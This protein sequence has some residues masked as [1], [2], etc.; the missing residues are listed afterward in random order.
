M[1]PQ[2]RK[3]E[4]NML[5]FRKHKQKLHFTAHITPIYLTRNLAV[6]KGCS[7]FSSLELIS[8]PTPRGAWWLREVFVYG[9]PQEILC[10]TEDLE[11]FDL[12]SWKQA[13][14]FPAL[15]RC[16]ALGIIMSRLS[17][18]PDLTVK[19]DPHHSSMAVWPSF[20]RTLETPQMLAFPQI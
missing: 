15:S 5:P 11:T 16:E 8:P 7:T 2:N 6:G 18:G 1:Y 10:S 4:R 3:E 14:H 20:L 12:Q 19:L 13:E 9:R 17:L